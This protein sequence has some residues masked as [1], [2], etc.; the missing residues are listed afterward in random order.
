MSRREP[1]RMEFSKEKLE[2][3]TVPAD[4][5][6]YYYDTKIPSLMVCVT[7][8]G[9]RTF[10]RGGRVRG[11]PVRIRLGRFGELTVKDARELAANV[12][13]QV[14]SGKNPAAE[15]RVR[16]MTLGE[17]WLWYR[18]FHA[19]PHKRTWQRDEKRW[20][21]QMAYLATKPIADVRRA[22]AIELQ[23]TI[24]AKYGK[25]AGN[26][27]L[28]QLRHMLTLAVEN[29]W[30]DAN[31]AMGIKRFPRKPRERFLTADELPRFFDAVGQLRSKVA[32]D[33]ILMLLFTGA[34]R[35]NVASMEW[36]ELDLDARTWTI[37]ASK[38][39]GKVDTTI[40]LPP[41]AVAIIE[42]RKGLNE[43]WVFG[44]FGPSGHYSWPKDAWMRV[45]KLA[46]LTGVCLH[47][48]RRTNASWQVEIGSSI[49]VIGKSLGHKSLQSTE[50]YAR[51]DRRKVRESVEGAVEAM[52]ATRPKKSAEPPK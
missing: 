28:E 25:H 33:F 16:K 23:T 4:G 52:L 24:A 34:R 22:D 14:A 2:R 1:A 48:L 5:R 26:H 37:P 18:D 19:K 29:G 38:Y 50:V 8:T 17:L 31:P 20:D 51:T 42:S 45:L 40:V 3:L 9:Q 11:R 43:K 30:L 32:R 49:A 41:A 12:A 7:S 44:G 35:G 27:C 39:K 36:R 47:D 46:N 10:Y 21:T 6:D 13:L 15:R